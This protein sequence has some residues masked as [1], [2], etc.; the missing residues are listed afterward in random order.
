MRNRHVD[1]ARRL[2][3]DTA[4]FRAFPAEERAAWRRWL[5]L[6]PVPVVVVIVASSGATW[7]V[8]G[9]AAFVTGL[10]IEAV[11]GPGRV[12]A[13]TSSHALI[14]ATR[15]VAIWPSAN[16]LIDRTERSAVE[17]S[18]AGLFKER[19]RFGDR[20]LIVPR[21]DGWAVDRWQTSN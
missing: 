20:S 15:R 6:L 21:D 5:S 4:I 11:D 17:R 2:S 8:I 9:A 7:P 19:W 18:A 3:P 12:V 1:A 14:F 16:R 10:L 13:L